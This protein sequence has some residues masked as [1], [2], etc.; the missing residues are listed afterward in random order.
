VPARPAAVEDPPEGRFAGRFE[1]VVA[2]DGPSGT[3]KSTVA[4]LLAR[5]LGVRYLDTGAMYRAATLAVLEREVD[6]DDHDRVADAVR[7]ASITISTDPERVGTTLDGRPVE[8]EIRSARVTAAVSLV[9]AVPAVRAVLVALQ[10]R[11][12]DTGAIVVEGRDIGSVVWPEAQVKF[13]LT[14]SAQARARRR[15]RELG[16][17]TDVSAVAADLQRRDELDSTRV[18][19]PL[20]RAADAL[21][22]DTTDLSI[23]EV[24]E[25]LVDTVRDRVAAS[26]GEG[27]A[28]P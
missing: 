3:G 23:D 14:A 25:R 11:L 27:G 15:A 19:S 28:G 9:S 8:A 2:L 24:V 17:G 6:V 21:E 18:V 7:E 22:V 10:R 20:A 5:R 12:I 1:G 26:T 13:Y 16:P 4:R